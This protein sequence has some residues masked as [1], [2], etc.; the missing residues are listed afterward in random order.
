MKVLIQ[1]GDSIENQNRILTLA[2]LLKCNKYQPYVLLYSESS[3]SLFIQNNIKT[4]YLNKYIKNNNIDVSEHVQLSETINIRKVL[5]VEKVRRPEICWPGRIKKTYQTVYS[6]WKAL[7]ELIESYKFDFVCIWNGF[8]GYVANCLRLL[9]LDKRIN[10][11]YMERGILKNSLFIDRKGVNGASSLACLK[12]PSKASKEETNEVLKLFPILSER[13]YSH[14]TKESSELTRIF[15]PLQVQNDT[16]IILY[17]K[18]ETMR[19]AFFDIYKHFNGKNVHFTVRPHPEELNST[20]INIPRLPNVEI[21]K[22]GT[23]QECLN[24]S[25]I[26]V[27]INS[28][29]GLEGLLEGKQ[30]YCLGDSI[31]SSLQCVY[32]LGNDENHSPCSNRKEII[33]NYLAHLLNRHLIYEN[34]PFCLNVLSN[35]FEAKFTSNFDGTERVNFKDLSNLRE[36]RIAVFL[37]VDLKQRLNLTYR[38]SKELITREYLNDI[39]NRN[40]FNNFFYT[41]D[42]AKAQIIIT[43]KKNSSAG[44]NQQAINIYG[45]MMS[46]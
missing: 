31:Y 19:E 15:F 13:N 8:T 5:E 29:V 1:C 7:D 38:K 23:L 4:I 37:D 46:R 12:I 21:N 42:K 35:I 14:K 3:G 18:Y 2:N 24:S 26:V 25:D 10:C 30:V 41:K 20:C 27:T 6:T 36:Q 22:K 17:S 16:N 44:K 9:A 40:G 11:A 32:H 45:F 28:T 34:G 43:D 39:L 33:I